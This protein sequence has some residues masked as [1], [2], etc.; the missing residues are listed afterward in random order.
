MGECKEHHGRAGHGH[1]HGCG[2]GSMHCAP[3]L[4]WG[5]RFFTREE[6]IAELEEYLNAL[7]AEASAVEETIA[8]LKAA[9]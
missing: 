4:F 8:E 6:R 1:H 2:G 9:K 7:K 5:R 3:G